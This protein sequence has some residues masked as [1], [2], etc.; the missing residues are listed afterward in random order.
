[1]Y[2]CVYLYYFMTYVCVCVF[3]L[4]HDVCM[5][6]CICTFRDV[7]MCVFALR[8][9]DNVIDKH[10]AYRTLTLHYLLNQSHVIIEYTEREANK[11]SL[12]YI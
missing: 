4:F 10:N 7:C 6:V 9:F 3:V 1:M 5:H 11:T 2:V 8:A 12:S